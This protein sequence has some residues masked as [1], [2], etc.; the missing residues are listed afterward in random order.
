M[1]KIL[2]LSIILIFILVG[3]GDKVTSNNED[4][5]IGNIKTLEKKN[6]LFD[7]F[8]ITYDNYIKSINDIISKDYNYK[9]D[10]TAFFMIDGKEIKGKDLKGKS[11]EDLKEYKEHFKGLENG[12]KLLYDSSKVKISKV[13]YDKD[14]NVKYIFSNIIK[15]YGDN[16][17][18]IINKMYTFRE[19]DENWKI[20]NIEKSSI[21]IDENTEESKEE[22]LKKLRYNN[23]DGEEME[24]VETLK[25][26]K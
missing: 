22:L 1:K 17:E 3:C 19:E 12:M 21:Y 4:E 8:Q 13:Y 24:Y 9:N 5:L 16:E 20:T 25:N 6:Y 2:I 26:N 14:L 10:D 18:E 23:Y 11:I 7:T 15:D